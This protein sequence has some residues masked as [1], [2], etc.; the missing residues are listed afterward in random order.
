MA[1]KEKNDGLAEEVVKL[2]MTI[3]TAGIPLLIKVLTKKK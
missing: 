1:E 3:L 2:G